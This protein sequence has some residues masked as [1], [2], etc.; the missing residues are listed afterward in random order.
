[1]TVSR[2]LANPAAVATDMATRIRGVIDR[3][4]YVPDR[5]AGRLILATQEGRAAYDPR[6]GMQD[7][8]NPGTQGQVSVK[9]IF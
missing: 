7:L 1:M 5:G 9:F 6:Y 8:F 2:L 3:L 4:G